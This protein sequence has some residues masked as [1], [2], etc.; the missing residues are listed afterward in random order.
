MKRYLSRLSNELIH[1]MDDNHWSIA[2]MS[3]MSESN[4]RVTVLSCGITVHLYTSVEFK[5]FK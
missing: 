1:K 4:F 3:A 2:H 5:N